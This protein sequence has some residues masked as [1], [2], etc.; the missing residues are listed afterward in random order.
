[1][2]FLTQVL[3][4]L[5]LGSIYA[6]VAL[7]YTMVYGIILLLN[8]AHG[9]IIMVGAYISWIVMAQLGMSPVLA[10][11]LSVVGCTVLGVLIDKVAYAPLRNA[12]RL[13]VLITAI[14]VSYFLENGAQLV[15]GADAK[16]VPT[17]F[18]LP[19]PQVG[20]ATFNGVAILTVV[21][22]AVSTIILTLLVQK[23]KFGKAMRAVSEDMGAAR[24]MGINVN[25]TISFTFAVGSALAG[26]GAVLYSMAYTQ[27][28]PTMGIML[29]TKAF[30]A[31]VLGGI[32][33]IPGAVIGGLLVGFAEVFVSAMGF[34]VWRDAVVFL[35]L[36]IVLIVKPTGILGR[37]MNEKV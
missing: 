15:F 17:Y 12:P 33:S 10:I 31:A 21:V 19:N 3:N 27:A 32:G 20:G 16:V 28:T 7:G 24:L 14:G 22:T 36:I 5:Q 8:F 18:N 9:D 23:T 11:I 13:S 25:N 4:G 30:V 29:G 6:L 2:T 37:T 35:L 1:M 26:I 34:S